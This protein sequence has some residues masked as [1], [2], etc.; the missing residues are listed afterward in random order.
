MWRVLVLASHSHDFAFHHRGDGRQRRTWI[1]DGPLVRDALQRRHQAVD[2]DCIETLPAN[3]S[4][5]TLDAALR[6]CDVLGHP[7][8]RRSRYARRSAKV[9]GPSGS[10]ATRHRLAVQPG[11]SQPARPIQNGPSRCRCK[12]PSRSGATTLLPHH[13]QPSPRSPFIERSARS[14]AA[15]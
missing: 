7:R 11:R 13:R 2:L 8:R 15:L 14:W 10:V 12:R 4:C 5:D 6:L 3:L 9:S 1:A